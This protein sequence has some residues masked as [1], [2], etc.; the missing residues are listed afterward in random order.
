M[1]NLL[2]TNGEP[3]GAIRH[4]AL[5]LCLA[6]RLAEAL[7]EKLHQI[8]RKELW[9]YAP[10]EQLSPEDCIGVKYQGIRPAPGYPTQPDHTE[11]RTLWQLMQIEEKSSIHIP[12]SL[13]MLRAASVSGLYFANP[14]CSYF[15]LGKV[16]KDQVEEYSQRKE[17]SVE[18]TERWLN[19]ILAYDN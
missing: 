11:K 18:A 10:E 4:N 3:T 2:L 17:Q 9:G 6:D 19:S 16:Q 7:A 1:E 5:A 15:S 12:E 8:V 13:A 14:H